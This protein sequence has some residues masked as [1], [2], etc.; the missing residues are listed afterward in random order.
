MGAQA[1]A[2]ARRKSFYEVVFAGS[3][4][5]V[6]GFM[7]GLRIGCAREG[8][9]I[10]NFDAGIHHEGVGEKLAEF[11]RLRSLDCHVVVDSGLAT[12]LR[13]QAQ[14]IA[15]EAGLEI[16]GCRHVRSAELPFE[17]TVYARHYYG[18]IMGLLKDL[19]RGVRLR[20]YEQELEERPDAKGPEAYS[21]VHDFTARG[22]G[23]LVG[24]VDLLVEFRERMSRQALI[25]EG[26]ILLHLA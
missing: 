9:V 21:P 13:R 15:D 16:K 7:A 6:R 8:V 4:K 3:P 20:D 26:E 14:R 25:K 18:E 22:R 19:P 23:K 1:R 11:V 5:V 2:V 24:R 10:F 12:L 17:F